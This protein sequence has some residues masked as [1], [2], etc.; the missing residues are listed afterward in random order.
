MALAEA[1]IEAAQRHHVEVDLDLIPDVR[2]SAARAEALIRIACEAV[3][4]AARHGRVSRVSVELERRGTG[5]LLRIS[6]KGLGFDVGAPGG[7]FGLV[8]MRERA[9][10]VGGELLVSST[11]GHGSQVEVAI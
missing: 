4:N 5:V 2:L 8:S 10:S 9:Q 3:T 1:V 6:D 11:P 7:G